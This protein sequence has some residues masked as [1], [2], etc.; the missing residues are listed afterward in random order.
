MRHHCCVLLVRRVSE[1]SSG[2]SIPRG[3]GPIDMTGAISSELEAGSSAADSTKQFLVHA[4]CSRGPLGA[5]L[6]Y[7]IDDE[8]HA[9]GLRCI[10]SPIF[11]ETG[12]A[13]AAVS[14]SGPM[15][16]MVDERVGPL[17]VL[18]LQAARDISAEMGAP[19][20]S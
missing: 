10:A 9:V 2:R 20:R 14:V 8:E 4:Y 11:D 13:I 1:A 19:Q 15:A 18:V 5:A 7:A 12:D 16:R 6:G 17:G 3:S